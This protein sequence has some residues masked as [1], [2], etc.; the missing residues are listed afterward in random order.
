MRPSCLEAVCF[1]VLFIFLYSVEG[2]RLEGSFKSSGHD[3]KLHEEA[4]MKISNG[5]MGDVIFRKQGQCRGN[6]RKL[7]TATTTATTTAS[8]TSSKSEDGGDYKK[9]NPTTT[10]K[11]GNQEN[12]EKQE[13]VSVSSPTSSEQQDQYADIME[14]A[15]MDYSPAKRKPPIHN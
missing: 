8:S 10:V 3:L 6:S 1:L 12:G 13:K 7:L 15:E 4:L 9:A 14:I 2:I 5:V 11:S